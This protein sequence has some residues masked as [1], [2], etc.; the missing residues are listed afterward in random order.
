MKDL[1][2]EEY[3]ANGIE[4]AKKNYWQIFLRTL[5]TGFLSVAAAVTVVGLF[6]LPA[7]LG[8]FYKFLLRSA[9]GESTGIMDSW[10]YGFQNGMWWKTLLLLVI[11]LIAMICGFL[12]LV[13]PGIYLATVW[14][15]AWFLLVDK[16]IL[17]TDS[18]QQ[19]RELVHSLGFW[20]VFGVYAI[21]TII[22][23]IISA[24]PLVNL[25]T[26]FLMPFYLMIYVAIYENSIQN[27]SSSAP[28]FKPTNTPIIE[29]K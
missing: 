5:V 25:L 3:F 17:P 21:L 12:L 11:S 14:L 24:I 7:I 20:K 29:Q 2:I 18:L 26:F 19:S 28:F 9:R 15:L 6:L 16:E 8:G 27:D 10:L 1:K 4:L 13:I 22:I 23:Q